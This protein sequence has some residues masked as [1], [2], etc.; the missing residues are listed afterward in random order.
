MHHAEGNVTIHVVMYSFHVHLWPNLPRSITL[1]RCEMRNVKSPAHP[2][3]QSWP[4]YVSLDPPL[5]A[6]MVLLLVTKALSAQLDTYAV[7][8]NVPATILATV[9]AV[10]AGE[11]P[12]AIEHTV[13]VS[14]VAW[15]RDHPLPESSK[16]GSSS[17]PRGNGPG[18]R[19][20]PRG[21]VRLTPDTLRW[22]S[23]QGQEQGTTCCY[24]RTATH[25]CRPVGFDR[26]L[27]AGTGP[28]RKGTPFHIPAMPFQ[29]DP[30]GCDSL[31]SGVTQATGRAPAG[32]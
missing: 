19:E 1:V 27:R 26:G 23:W 21:R 2:Q 32:L 10:P 15:C 30:F 4:E 25:P 6:Q 9:N 7:A 22:L 8:Y 29:S 16:A 18:S 13:L 24:S 28:T 31:V 3:Q 20:V 11:D 12:R 5:N 17:H 14:L